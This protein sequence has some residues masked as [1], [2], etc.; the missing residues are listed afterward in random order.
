LTPT[1]HFRTFVIFFFWNGCNIPFLVSETLQPCI[2][3]FFGVSFAKHVRVAIEISASIFFLPILVTKSDN[4]TP[5]Q[6][7][8]RTWSP[9]LGGMLR[10]TVGCG[11]EV[12]HCHFPPLPLGITRTSGIFSTSF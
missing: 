2:G 10:I 3:F 4:F 6:F 5:R 8:A 12:T 9:N 1:I 11:W 7:S